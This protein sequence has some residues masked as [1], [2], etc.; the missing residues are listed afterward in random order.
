MTSFAGCETI[1]KVPLSTAISFLF[2]LITDPHLLIALCIVGAGNARTWEP[3]QPCSTKRHRYLRIVIARAI[4]DNRRSHSR[5][6]K[7]DVPNTS[8]HHDVSW[9]LLPNGHLRHRSGVELY[10]DG[11]RWAMTQAS[12]LHF[13]MYSMR[14]CSLSVNEAKAMADKLLLDG[15]G[16]LQRLHSSQVDNHGVPVK[17]LH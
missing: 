5:R 10:N 2:A 1:A 15:V 6:G 12:A 8:L 14:T 3:K 9:E 16:W 4:D 13:V 7:P 17:S 11:R